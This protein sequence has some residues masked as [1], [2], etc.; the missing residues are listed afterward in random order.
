MVSLFVSSKTQVGC[1][2]LGEGVVACDPGY[3]E[4]ESR[5]FTGKEVHNRKFARQCEKT[6]SQKPQKNQ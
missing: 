3:L 1:V 2:L 4:G 6:P 5:K